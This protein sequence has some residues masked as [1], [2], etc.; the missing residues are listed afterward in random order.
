MFFI[1]LGIFFLKIK[2]ISSNKENHCDDDINEQKHRTRGQNRRELIHV[3]RLQAFIKGKQQRKRYHLI[4]SAQIIIAWFW[5]KIWRRKYRKYAYKIQRQYRKHVLILAVINIQ[6]LIR[7][8]L[9]R[10]S[11]KRF[12]Q[13]RIV[14]EKHRCAIE[15]HAIAKIF[16]KTASM[17]TPDMSDDSI[18]KMLSVDIECYAFIHNLQFNNQITNSLNYCINNH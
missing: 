12:N 10:R 1:A 8:F 11:A 3:I 2:L 9:S 13:K 18:V 7:G 16:L 17:F 4:K 14:L 6:R 15:Q 5:R